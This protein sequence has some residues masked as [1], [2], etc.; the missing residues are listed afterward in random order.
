MTHEV[1][2]RLQEARDALGSRLGGPVGAAVVL[3]SGL[4]SVLGEE[5]Q[6]L[7]LPYEAVPHLPRPGV[8]GHG[9]VLACLKRGNLRVLVFSGRVHA[10]EGRSG[11]ELAF[12]VR[13]SRLLGASRVLLTNAAGGIAPQLEPGTLMVIRDHLNLMGQNPLRGDNEERLGPRFP[14]MSA[15]YDPEGQTLMQ[16]VARDLWGQELPTGVYA[17]CPG[18]AYETPAEVRMLGLLGADAVGMSTVPEAIAARHAG[19][20]VMGLSLISNRAA[21]LGTGLLDHSEVTRTADAAKGRLQAFL[22]ALLPRLQGGG[23]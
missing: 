2:D 9:G 12:A 4:S 11:D 7:S 17:A 1:W 21:G 20:K 10:Y 8:Q 14:D 15:V 19:L 16:G 22:N 13:L 5:G 3:G 18:P 23:I 6:E